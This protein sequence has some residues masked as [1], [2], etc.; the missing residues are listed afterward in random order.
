MIIYLS[1]GKLFKAYFSEIIKFSIV[2]SFFPAR[3]YTFFR[4]NNCPELLRKKEKF[5]YNFHLQLRKEYEFWQ[6]QGNSDYR[7]A[8]Q[9]CQ[10]FFYTAH[11]S[12]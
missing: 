9:R 7:K 6:L 8:V 11:L 2:L 3:N 5:L 12:V 4:T 10:V 1:W